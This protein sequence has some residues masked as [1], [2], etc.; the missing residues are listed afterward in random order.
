MSNPKRLSEEDRENLLDTLKMRFEENIHRH[1]GIN[2]D[3]VQKKIVDNDEYLNS[4]YE[5]EKSG[6][7][8]DIVKIDGKSGIYCFIDCAQETPEE[9]RNLCYDDEALK[10]RKKN[11]PEG[12]AQ[13]RA[14]EIGIRLLT[15]EEY[16][17][18]QT[19]EKVDTKTS[20]WIDTPE[21]IRR[22]GGALF[23]DRRYGAV[24][25]YHNGAESYYG[26][27]GY[28]GILEIR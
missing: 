17:K 13:G 10:S 27:R 7:E 5:M 8:P 3:H 26:A 19:F 2:W 21:S 9:R 23:G 15:E 28:R 20:S 6:G 18:L 25:I 24:F 1:E 16:R 12:S 4:L 11:K 22:L 14:S